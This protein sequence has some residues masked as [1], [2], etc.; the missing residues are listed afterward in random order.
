[1]RTSVPG[2]DRPVRRPRRLLVFLGFPLL[3]LISTAFKSPRELTK[4]EPTLFP[5]D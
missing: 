3:W 5:T 4:I 1:M 2:P